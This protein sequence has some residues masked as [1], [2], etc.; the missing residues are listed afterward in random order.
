[1]KKVTVTLKFEFDTEETDDETVTQLIV[2]AFE[3]RVE[4][5]ELL[6]SGAKVKIVDT[7]PDEDEDPEIEDDED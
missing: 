7:E 5:N 2:D 6:E 4:N 1:M 3:E